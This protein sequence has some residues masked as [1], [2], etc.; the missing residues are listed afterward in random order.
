MG[1]RYGAKQT[2]AFGKSLC[3]GVAVILSSLLTSSAMGQEFTD[4]LSPD[5]VNAMFTAAEPVIMAGLYTG[6]ATDDSPQ[7]RVDPNTTTSPF[8]GVG[9]LER[10]ASGRLW[11]TAVPVT[12]W[13]LLTAGH[14]VDVD[15][16]GIPDVAPADLK[17]YLNSGGDLSSI[18]GI[19]AIAMHP[20]FT[21]F[22]SPALNDDVAILTLSSPI[23]QNVPV[24]PLLKRPM[25]QGD[26][27]TLVGYGLTGYGNAGFIYIPATLSTKRVG[28]NVADLAFLDEEGL[29]YPEVY[30]FDFDG[31]TSTTN[32]LGGL[33]LGDKIETTLGNG[34]SG[35]PAFVWEGGVLQLA[36]I[37]TFIARFTASVAEPPKFGSAGGGIMIFPL[38]QWIAEQTGISWDVNVV[39][40]DVQGDPAYIRPG[41]TIN[42]DLN[43]LRLA[44]RVT[45][46]QAFLNFSSAHFSTASGDVNVAAGGGVWDELIYSMHNVAGDLDVAVGV[47]MQTMGGTQAD[48]TAAVFTLKATGEGSTQLV[49]RPDAVHDPEL[50]NTTILSD[51]MNQTILPVK[52]NSQV[53]VIDGSAP[54]VTVLSPNGGEFLKGGQ[55]VSITWNVDE[56]NLDPALT[57]VEFYDGQAWQVLATGLAGQTFIW[58]PPQNLNTSAAMVRV[59]A[60]DRAGNSASDSSD[61]AFTVDSAAPVVSALAARQGG[62]ELIP[63][64]TAFQGTVEIEVIA[65][66]NLSGITAPPQMYVTPQGAG[67]QQ[68]AYVNESPAGVYH[69]AWQVTSGT[70]NGQAALTVPAFTDR[71][72]NQS[73]P[74]T[75]LL[76]VNKN[77]IVGTVQFKTLSSTNYSFNRN[78]VLVATNAQGQVLKQW[79]VNVAFANSPGTQTATGQFG[80]LLGVPV[81]GLANLS[82]KTAWHLRQRQPVSLDAAG[83]GTTAFSLLGGDLDGSNMV[84]ILDYSLMKA[85]WGPGQNADIN[86]DRTTGILDYSILKDN[87]FEAGSPP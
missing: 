70:P 72:G 81:Q 14:A 7:L 46:L 83:Q 63:G 50:V 43:V 82:A 54:V 84:N 35:G 1:V 10:N 42:I 45:G 78:V 67:A 47:D 60:T 34:D 61:S 37:N 18:H 39:Q 55:D 44:Q 56:P 69:Y 51:E 40:L 8:A 77:Q 79:T 28:Q 20:N 15:H 76:D 57:K 5:D 74:V 32:S 4:L 23:P 26:V 38:G 2:S 11:A 58:Q 33:T 27:L 87:W 22:N 86:G 53:I 66:D 75:A 19:T 36:G 16:N 71:S 31:P 9:S 25:R 85:A 30:V 52:V 17:F 64:G 41:E 24:Y 13:H 6:A 65:S 48:A 62:T 73:S 12:R 80:P 49:F 68:A 59:T 3:M 21:G 29:I